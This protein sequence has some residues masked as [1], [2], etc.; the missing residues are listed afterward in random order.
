MV[1]KSWA[2]YVDSLDFRVLVE[3]RVALLDTSC[4]GRHLVVATVHNFELG[5]DGM[6]RV[7]D[8]LTS[9]VAAAKAAPERATVY[10]PG[11]FNH[12]EN[13]GAPADDSRPAESGA[14]PS[15]GL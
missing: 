12:V 11:D 13:G 8:T 4:R 7:K 6:Q 15:A 10:I 1:R 3:G 14:A 9:W 5:G 2:A